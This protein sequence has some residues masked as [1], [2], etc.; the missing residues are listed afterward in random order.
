MTGSRH[1]EA[2]R[3]G[4]Q[5]VISRRAFDQT[6]AMTMASSVQRWSDEPRTRAQLVTSAEDGSRRPTSISRR[7]CRVDPSETGAEQEVRDHFFGSAAFP[8]GSDAVLEA[9]ESCM[10][11]PL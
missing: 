1:S 3:P 5:P 10:P 2:D 7:D 6:T 8:L 9:G 11:W 4:T